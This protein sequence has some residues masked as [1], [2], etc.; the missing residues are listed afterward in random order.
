MWPS[1]LLDRVI[2]LVLILWGLWVIVSEWQSIWMSLRHGFS[3]FFFYDVSSLL[4][5]VVLPL[6]AVASGIGLLRAKKWAWRPVRTL[7]LIAFVVYTMIITNFTIATYFWW[8]IPRPPMP[9]D[10]YVTRV[11]IW[12]AVIGA[13]V[14]G[15]LTIVIGRRSE[16]ALRAEEPLP[17]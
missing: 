5:G 6:V 4:F 3:G 17:D 14:S 15:V 10:A 12:P 16:Q 11:S 13:L 8:N 7:S 2:A 1:K 9:D